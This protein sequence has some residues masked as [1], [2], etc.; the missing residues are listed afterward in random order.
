MDDDEVMET[1]NGDARDDISSLDR[2]VAFKVW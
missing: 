1:S 2:K